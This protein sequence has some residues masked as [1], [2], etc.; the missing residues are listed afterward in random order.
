MK[1][2]VL[3]FL[4]FALPVALF[5][6][7]FNALFERTNYWKSKDY[8][9]KYTDAP[10]GLE[11]GN[12]GSSIPCYALKYDEVPDIKAWNFAN[13]C[14]IY[15]LSG[16]VLK[17]YINHFNE[18][19][20]VLVEIPYFGIKAR[21]GS[22]RERYYRVL[23][24]EDMDGWT[25]SEWL[26]YKIFPILSAGKFKAAVFRDIPKEEMS[27]FYD[28]NETM[29]EEELN[30]YAKKTYDNFAS[31]PQDRREKNFEEVC[32]IIDLCRANNTV[33]VLIAFPQSDVFNALYQSEGGF[34]EEYERFV[35][36]LQEKYPGLLF[37]DYSRDEK[38]AARHDYFIDAI[39]MNNSGAKEF[40]K[41][42]ISDLRALGLLK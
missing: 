4:L 16:K 14:E 5:F 30:D 20:V 33:P 18:N 29:S 19:A 15:E 28:R 38:F 34:F 9:N 3:K 12:I 6:L 40:T 32:A 10:Y 2:F 41:T 39:H 7:A 31:L 24:K 25:F 37:L 22:F 13:T 11:L 26:A 8:A 42:V 23:P 35:K 36:D 27:P 17:N 21:L 1:R